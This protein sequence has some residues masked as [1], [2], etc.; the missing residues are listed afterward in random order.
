[1]KDWELWAIGALVKIHA[2]P[3]RLVSDARNARVK[4]TFGGSCHTIKFVRAG[5]LPRHTS[6][7]VMESSFTDTD[8]ERVEVAVHLDQYGD[9]YELDMYRHDGK[10]ITS[11]PSAK[12]IGPVA[13]G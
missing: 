13:F 9:L 12:N 5:K 1:M 10:D 11:H 8:G 2:D 4:Q 7:P 3:E 6:G